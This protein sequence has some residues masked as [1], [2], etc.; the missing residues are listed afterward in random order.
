MAIESFFKI[1]W[2]PSSLPQFRAT[3]RIHF[4]PL[5]HFCCRI[6]RLHKRKTFIIYARVVW[7]HKMEAWSLNRR[8]LTWGYAITYVPVKLKVALICSKVRSGPF[9]GTLINRGAA[10]YEEMGTFSS[11]DCRLR[12]DFHGSCCKPRHSA[13]MLVASCGDKTLDIEKCDALPCRL[14][15][16]AGWFRCG[17]LAKKSTEKVTT[18]TNWFCDHNR[19][20]TTR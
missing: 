2:E 9:L 16:A 17:D 15:G 12:R 5:S 3:V 1:S 13:E 6:C 14:R 20:S 7:N 18:P 8:T 19:C 10:C 4:L 11:F